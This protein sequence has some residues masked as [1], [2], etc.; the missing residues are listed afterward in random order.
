MVVIKGG[1]IGQAQLQASLLAMVV[2]DVEESP[3]PSTKFERGREKDRMRGRRQTVR[4]RE[5]QTDFVSVV[6]PPS[7][8][9]A[10]R[11]TRW[12]VQ[13]QQGN[14]CILYTSWSA[15]VPEGCTNRG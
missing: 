2:T 1:K 6:H 10:A 5:R 9:A 7:T 8:A 3:S 14:Y 15:T 13:R 12:E 4:E 11:G